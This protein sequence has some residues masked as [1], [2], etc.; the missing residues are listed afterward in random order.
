MIAISPSS[1]PDPNSQDL[2][3]EMDEMDEMDE[4]GEIGEIG[5]IL[6]VG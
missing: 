6:E 4:I 5:E 2:N 1:G 3:N